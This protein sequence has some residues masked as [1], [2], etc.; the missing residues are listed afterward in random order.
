VKFLLVCEYWY[1]SA[2]WSYSHTLEELGCQVTIFDYR[3]RR[4]QWRP[5]RPRLLKRGLGLVDQAVMNR[6]LLRCARALCP[7]VILVTKG[8]TLVPRTLRRLR[9]CGRPLLLNYNADSPFNPVNSSRALLD[10]IPVY[11]CHFAWARQL[12]TP[13]RRAGA[14]RVEYLPFGFDPALF[15]PVAVSEEQ[16]KRYA[17]EVCFAGTWEPA[18][19]DILQELV[20]WDL[21]VWGNMWENVP[22]DSP[23]RPHL[24]GAAI[25]AEELCRRLES[26]KII[27]NLLRAQNDGATNM[28]TFEIPGFGGFL[29]TTRSK[30]QCEFFAEGKEIE[31]FASVE[32]LREKI[33]YYLRHGDERK[34]IARAGHERALTEHTLSRRLKQMLAVAER[35]GK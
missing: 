31:C 25:Y 28:R 9:D 30:E 27:L 13:L 17:S 3:R 29:L 14:R 26:A 34:A 22:Q 2:G 21:S 20:G 33:R 19:E 18:R 11:D 24:K 32:E 23:L 6:Q 35:L 4:L 8:E 5:G 1:G 12:V 16:R 7:D 10:S 15:H